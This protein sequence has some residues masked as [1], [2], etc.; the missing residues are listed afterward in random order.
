M[1]HSKRRRS[2]DVLELGQGDCR[3]QSRQRLAA[4]SLKRPRLA[5]ESSPDDDAVTD[6]PQLGV[7]GDLAISNLRQPATVPTLEVAR[8]GGPGPRPGD[9]AD[10]RGPACPFLSVGDIVDGVVDDAVHTHLNAGLLGSALATASG[11]D[12]EADDDSVGHRPETSDLEMH[13]PRMDGART[14]TSSLEI[15]SA[16]AAASAGPGRRATMMGGSFAIVATVWSEQV[17]SVTLV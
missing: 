13:R 6:G 17:V 5:M 10:L 4:S 12:V 2:L 1:K 8:P 14:R 16:L 9:L 15:F 3:T 7:A 11:T